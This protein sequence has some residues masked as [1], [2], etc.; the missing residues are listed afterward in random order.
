MSTLA[1]IENGENAVDFIDDSEIENR[2]KRPTPDSARLREILDK[3]LSKQ[4]L[5]LDETADLLLVEDPGMLEQIFE[6]AG[7]L[8]HDIYGK[9][10][11][12]FAP[13]YIGNNCVNDCPYCGFKRSNPDAIRRTLA[14]EEIQQ[15]VRALQDMGHKRLILVYGEH[16][17]YDADY[18]AH[19]METVYATEGPVGEIR[20]V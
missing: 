17:Q 4:C 18:I 1:S 12:L 10:I 16:P 14:D 13:L 3:S 5:D 6:A 9:R 11:V 8:K 2:L 19:T 7:R 15:Q 20:R